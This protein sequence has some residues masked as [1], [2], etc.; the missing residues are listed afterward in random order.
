[1]ITTM[2]R[3]SIREALPDDFKNYAD[4]QWDK[5]TTGAIMTRLAKEHPEKYSEVL[6][7]LND[8]GREVATRY[9]DEASLDYDE[10]APSKPV[11]RLQETVRGAM[12]KIYNDKNL[13]PDQKR[14]KVL[15]LGTKF[16]DKV[17]NSVAED[18]IKQGRGL[19]LQLR[20]GARGSPVQ[21]MQL[22]FGNMLMT[23]ARGRTIPFLGTQNY[24]DGTSPLDYWLGASSSRKSFYDVQ[25]ATAESG[26][27]SKQVSNATGT[28]P[29]VEDDCGT[30]RS[31]RM[32]K[33][34][35]IDN[36]GA[37]LLRPF[38][39]YKAG[40][41]VTPQM[42]EGVSDKAKLFVRSALTCRSKNGV[43]A[44][45]AG[46]KGD[47]KFPAVGEFMAFN[48]AKAFTE[49]LT[50]SSVGCLHPGTMV[51]MADGSIKQIANIKVGDIVLGSDKNGVA[52][53][54]RVTRVFE[55]GT[56]DVWLTVFRDRMSKKRKKTLVSTL[57][58]KMLQVTQKSNCKEEAF[59]NIPRILTAGVSG[60]K[61]FAFGVQDVRGIDGVDFDLALLL[62]LMLGDGCYSPG[63]MRPHFSCADPELLEDIKEY[64]AGHGLHTSFHKGSSCYYRVSGKSSSAENPCSALLRK[65]G[66]MGL[67]AH[68]KTI[69]DDAWNFDKNS[70]CGLLSGLWSTDGSI[71]YASGKSYPYT[72]FASTSVRM[73][74]AARDLIKKFTG[75]DGRLKKQTIGRKR[76]LYQ[77][78]YCTAAGCL[79]VLRFLR[80]PGVKEHKRLEGIKNIES[81]MKMTKPALCAQRYKRKEQRYIGKVNTFDIEVDNEDHLFVLANGLIVSNSKHAAEAKMD[82]LEVEDKET[83]LRAVEQMLEAPS[84]F[85]GRA[86]LSGIP[87]KVSDI[88]SAPQGGYRVYVNGTLAAYVPENRKVLVK[89]G[90]DVEEGDA[91]TNGIPNPAE[92][93]KYKGLGA[94]REYFIDRF[95]QELD[96]A[97]SST[98][99]R[100]VELFDRA[101]LNK[102]RITDPQGF[103][104][105]LPGDTVDYSYVQGHWQPRDNAVTVS[106]D[107][108]IGKYLEEPVLHH[109]IG[110]KVTPKVA[111]N[112]KEAEFADVTVSDSAPPFEPIFVRAN[113]ILESSPN[114]ESRLIGERLRPAIFDA[115]QIG[116]EVR[117]DDPT[118][119]KQIVNSV[120]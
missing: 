58:H 62:G 68:E 94:G 15:A 27:L 1:M 69:P 60:A 71:Y 22:L 100:N 79:Q 80:L 24:T 107:K 75:A 83:G 65:Y 35:D 66:M 54:A 52:S 96:D 103:A 11:R 53:P 41:A 59:N 46:L 104:G 93:V 64:L 108:A 49:P 45:C 48:A 101:F 37:V 87:G 88:T 85:R 81:F 116:A 113:Q 99:R 89:K 13:T 51:R 105:F 33:A 21:I 20:S 72:S 17:K 86:V 98:T 32:V 55:K 42:L 70:A 84:T 43:C 109:T 95:K 111:A 120:Y 118:M 14:A 38:D 77:L 61:V 63:V 10:L 39:N 76:P 73:A 25:F 47:G 44:K 12:F 67:Y 31:G 57:D 114:W 119:Y 110:T 30:T 7:R 82:D 91:L 106:P 40:T 97:N 112:L 6:Q 117:D 90:D 18:V 50:Q 92:V 2:G 102:V 26:Y 56:Q 23:D 9:G 19:G 16:Y 74:C 36:V 78:E 29:I 28:A 4:V 5:K 3:E 34:N 115:A 8:I